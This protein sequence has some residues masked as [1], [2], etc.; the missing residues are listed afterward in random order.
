MIIYKASE[1]VAKLKHIAQEVPSGY[2]ASY[3]HNLGYWDGKKFTWDCIC[4]I[5]SLI[6][7]WEEIRKVGY[8]AAYKASTGMGDWTG[9]QIMDHCKDV[10]S[11][12]SQLIPGED[13]MGTDN[14]HSGIYVGE[15]IIGGKTYNV[16]ECTTAWGGGV[17]FS[18]V[19]NTGGRYRYKGGAKATV[20]WKCHGKLDSWI[21]YSDQPEPPVVT[22]YIVKRGD[23]LTKI[24]KEYNTTVSQ[25]VAWNG[26][27]NPNLIFV[28]QRLIVSKSAP[29]PQPVVEYYTVQRG[30]NL[31]KIAKKFGATV[32]QLV[33]WNHIVNPNIIITGQ[34]LRV[35]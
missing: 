31:T 14:D 28:G 19:S 6:W 16:V 25:L 24:A 29:G 26:I 9:R 18:Y 22:Y 35:K 32:A 8:Y 2:Y 5:K 17:I 27:I 21:D 20:S 33:R 30:D 4:L 3:P 10:S 15:T 23:N 12:F 11:D 7:G 34:V 1:F 13:L